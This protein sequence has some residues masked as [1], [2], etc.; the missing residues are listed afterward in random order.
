MVLGISKKRYNTQIINW[1]L[2]RYEL[3]NDYRDFIHITLAPFNIAGQRK[4]PGKPGN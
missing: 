3:L 1:F 4:P 2:G